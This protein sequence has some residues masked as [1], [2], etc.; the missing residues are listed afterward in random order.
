[1]P[2]S[3]VDSFFVDCPLLKGGGGSGMGGSGKRAG[4]Q[5]AGA[6]AESISRGGT[7]RL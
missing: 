7:S 4:G 6:V 5:G 3:L 2:Q 1:V